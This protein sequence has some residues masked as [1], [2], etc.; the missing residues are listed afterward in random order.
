MAEEEQP[1]LATLD[2]IVADTREKATIELDDG[3][4]IEG[5]L[6]VKGEDKLADIREKAI[7]ELA[8][9]FKG[10]L[11]LWP[12]AVFENMDVPMDMIFQ[13]DWAL[14]ALGCP[15]LPEDR[16]HEE[17]AYTEF[18]KTLAETFAMCPTNIDTNKLEE[19]TSA[20]LNNLFEIDPTIGINLGT[21]IGGINNKYHLRR[22]ICPAFVEYARR[23]LG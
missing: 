4:K 10:I 17:K 3:T 6:E 13:N 7:K 5:I 21:S 20:M 12:N 2:Q 8:A 9:A 19:S 23:Y 11:D 1:K 18:Y 22:L 14:G 15:S 16:K